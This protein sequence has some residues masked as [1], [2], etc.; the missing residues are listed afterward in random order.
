MSWVY[1]IAAGCLEVAFASCLSASNGFTR[2]W[3]TLGFI[4]FGALSFLALSRALTTIPIGTA[5][6][7]WAGIGAVGTVLVGILF[8][9]EPT[10][11][12]RL[13]FIGLLIISIVGLKFFAH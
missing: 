12:T 1:L 9:G 10:N 6:A 2:I 8:L 7:V 3:P 13:F 5:Y 11:A 4:L